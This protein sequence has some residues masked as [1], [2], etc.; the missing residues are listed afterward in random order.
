[1]TDAPD[2]DELWEQFHYVVNMNSRELREW[3]QTQSAGENAEVVPEDAG[4][5]V[6]QQVLAIL[7]K[8]KQDLTEDDLSVMGSVIDTVTSQRG[9]DMEST[10]GDAAWR[11]GL[12]NIGHDPLKPATDPR[13]ASQPH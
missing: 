12:M 5:S 9:E 13:P 4:T 7:G 6:G 10:A 3:L 1:M 8:R 2:V 11:H